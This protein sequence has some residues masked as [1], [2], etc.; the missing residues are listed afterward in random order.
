MY[1]GVAEL[2]QENLDGFL[3]VAEEFQLRGLTGDKRKDNEHKNKVEKKP[4]LSLMMKI[5][6]T[7]QHITICGKSKDTTQDTYAK[8]HMVS[9][10]E[11][12]RGCV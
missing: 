8:K 2:Y 4:T 5:K 1:H 9:H 12:L 10:V 3:A 11:S 7:H 6:P